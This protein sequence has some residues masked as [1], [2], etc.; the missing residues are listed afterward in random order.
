[1]FTKITTTSIVSV[2]VMLCGFILLT[3]LC[4]LPTHIEPSEKTQIIAGTIALMMLCAGYYFGASKQR[5]VTQ[6]A[7]TITNQPLSNETGTTT[8]I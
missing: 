8:E 6:Q 5:G 7:D 2:I 3:A 1:M 4:F